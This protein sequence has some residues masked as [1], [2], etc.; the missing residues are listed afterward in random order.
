MSSRREGA[1]ISEANDAPAQNP[2]SKVASCSIQGV[3]SRG[4]IIVNI[5]GVH[6]CLLSPS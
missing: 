2:G 6:E 5:D 1:G 4:S 3:E